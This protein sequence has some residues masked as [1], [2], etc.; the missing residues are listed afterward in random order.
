MLLLCLQ[1]QTEETG[2]NHPRNRHLHPDLYGAA[3][4]HIKM[5]KMIEISREFLQEILEDLYD[6]RSEWDWRKDEPRCNYQR[7]YNRLCERIAMIEVRLN[8]LKIKK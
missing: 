3:Y 8:Q 6:L 1:Q 7:D 4:L 2:L 5:K